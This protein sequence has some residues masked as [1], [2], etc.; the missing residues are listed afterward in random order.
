[1]PPPDVLP[2]WQDDYADTKKERGPGGALA[3]PRWP[4]LTL[5]LVL[6]LAVAAAAF[7][8][9]SGGDEEGGKVARGGAKLGALRREWAAR[10]RPGAKAAGHGKS[11]KKA[12]HPADEDDEPE[13]PAE[14]A[15]DEALAGDE[16][17]DADVPRKNAVGKKHKGSG[18][19]SGKHKVKGGSGKANEHAKDEDEDEEPESRETHGKK[20]P[21]DEEEEEPV[22]PA[23]PAPPAP[24]KAPPAPPP[25]AP[26]PI[27]T[28]I[29]LPNPEDVIHQLSGA[30]QKPP[31]PPPPPAPAHVPEHVE[32]KRNDG[33][34]AP[35]YA[36]ADFPALRSQLGCHT[37]RCDIH[38]LTYA[39]TM[40]LHSWRSYMKYAKGS[41]DLYP[42][43]KAPRNWYGS[44]SLLNTP[45][46]ALDT[47]W[48]AGL[49]EEYEE[50]RT[51]VETFEPNW[52]G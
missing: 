8:L 2:R 30:G 31:S 3:A 35:P 24:A 45:I 41:D 10:R 17:E 21:V 40:I 11:G 9:L 51:L 38:N 34:S 27:K 12:K 43:N 1:M 47:L 25:P 5:R 32:A 13:A 7:F 37:P 52:V 16:A 49:R 48:L 19:S 33:A 39:R 20:R 4:K 50:A 42:M 23:K 22:K 18:D 46:D 29:S 6:L 36:P 15:E 26:I 14:D 44:H 28:D